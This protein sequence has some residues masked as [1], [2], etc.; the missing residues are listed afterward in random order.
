M[1]AVSQLFLT[2]VSHSTATTVAL[3]ALPEESAS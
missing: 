1:P 3:T 2:P